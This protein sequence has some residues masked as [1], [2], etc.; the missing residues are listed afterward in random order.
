M[1]VSSA[2]GLTAAD[3]IIER[4]LEIGAGADAALAAEQCDQQLAFAAGDCQRSPWTDELE[5]IGAQEQVAEAAPAPSRISRGRRSRARHRATSSCEGEGLHQ[6]VVGAGVQPSDAI[7]DGCAL[8]NHQDAAATP[9][10]ASWR[11]NSRPSPS[12]RPR[13]STI[14]SVSD[15]SELVA[16]HRSCGAS[17]PGKRAAPSACTVAAPS[18]LLSSIR[19]M[20]TAQPSGSEVR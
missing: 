10:R 12:G 4:A 17:R 7:L 20:V 2:F 16:R 14:R 11:R 8:G 1:L 3:G 15:Q 19:S 6:V 5:R 9:R 18:P 13:S